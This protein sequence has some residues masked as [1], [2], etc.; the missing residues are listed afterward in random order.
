M[1][2]RPPQDFQEALLQRIQ[3]CLPQFDHGNLSN[4]VFGLARLDI[5]P[6]NEW[7]DAFCDRVFEQLPHMGHQHLTDV[8]WSLAVR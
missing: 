4:T 2:K 1:R 6:S 8:L 5:R 3:H 7:L